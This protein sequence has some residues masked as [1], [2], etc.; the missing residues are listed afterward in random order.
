MMTK[1]SKAELE[2]INPGLNDIKAGRVHT[3]DQVKSRIE[4]KIELLRKNA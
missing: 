4:K 3:M 1:L 2:S